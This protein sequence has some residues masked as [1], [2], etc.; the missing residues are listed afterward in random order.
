MQFLVITAHNSEYYPLIPTISSYFGLLSELTFHIKRSN[1]AHKRL[2]YNF[3]H[4]LFTQFNIK[5]TVLDFVKVDSVGRLHKQQNRRNEI[6]SSTSSPMLSGER[7]GVG[8]R[9]REKEGRTV[10]GCV[11][12]WRITGKHTVFSHQSA[13][14]G[15]FFFFKSRKI[16]TSLNSISPTEI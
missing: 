7:W 12:I 13:L 3:M 9:E 14:K 5:R 10:T 4:N 16:E 15:F 8:T 11:V 1:S 2:Q 6:Y